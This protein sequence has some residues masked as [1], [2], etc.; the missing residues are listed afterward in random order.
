MS[1]RFLSLRLSASEFESRPR[2]SLSCHARTCSGHLRAW[3]AGTSPAM[4][5]A[6]AFSPSPACGRGQG[7]GESTSDYI[8]VTAPHPRP[9]SRERERGEE[10]AAPYAATLHC[11][12]R[13]PGRGGRRRVYPYTDGT[14]PSP[15]PSRE[16]EGNSSP[17]AIALSLKP[18]RNHS[19]TARS[20]FPAPD[21]KC[22]MKIQLNRCLIRQY[23]WPDDSS[24]FCRRCASGASRLF[25]K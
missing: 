9:L 2:N 6:W 19:L 1:A 13:G 7:E 14:G 17:N 20:A 4:T 8:V 24:N 5:S 23:V 18:R 21:E 15:P 11:G 25:D 12:G 16:G 22:R 3:I 10:G